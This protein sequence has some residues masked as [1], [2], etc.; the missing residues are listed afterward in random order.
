MLF[1]EIAL[2]V[3]AWRRG[4]RARALWPLGIG[5]GIGFVVGAALSASGSR[6]EQLPPALLL[7][8]VACIAVLIGMVCRPPQPVQQSTLAESPLPPRVP[9]QPGMGPWL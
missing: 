6:V 2:T 1:I 5:M 8:D 3:A 4:W 9:S 7:F